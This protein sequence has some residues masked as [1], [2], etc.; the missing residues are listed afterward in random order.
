MAMD[1]DGVCRVAREGAVVFALEDLGVLLVTGEDRQSWLNGMVTGDVAKLEPGARLEV[2]FTNVKGKVVALADVWHAGDCLRVVTERERIGVL[3]TMLERLIVMEDVT[4]ADDSAAWSVLSVQGP[5][6]QAVVERAGLAGLPSDR[7]GSGGFDLLQPVVD[8]DAA[9]ERLLDAG[10][11]RGSPAAL[12]ALRLEAAAPRWGADVT[13]DLFPQEARLEAHRVSF[14]KGCYVGQEP[15]TRLQ[16]RGHANR[17]LTPL[18]LGDAD[19]PTAGAVVRRGDAEVGRITSS[20][21]GP[22]VGRTIA[23]ALLRREAAGPGTDLDVDGTP[24]KVAPGPF[25]AAS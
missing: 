11:V 9:V 17:F 8:S 18:D 19:P 5:V 20:A 14:T 22:T 10:A 21:R 7:T 6:A 2:C 4:I 13:D 16:S 12:E 3:L 15:V 1:I 23:L 25:V 24:A